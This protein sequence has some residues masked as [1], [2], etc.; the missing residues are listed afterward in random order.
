M[1]VTKEV[2]YLGR[3]WQ[4]LAGHAGTDTTWRS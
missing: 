3:G 2:G 4:G 1:Q